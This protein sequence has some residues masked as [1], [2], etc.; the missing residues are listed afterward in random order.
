VAREN[1]LS[2]R[3]GSFGG[4]EGQGPLLRDSEDA[5]GNTTRTQVSQMYGWRL[6]L[7]DLLLWVSTA[8]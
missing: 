5:S 1:V 3:I 6:R 4:R 8:A 7:E 2:Y